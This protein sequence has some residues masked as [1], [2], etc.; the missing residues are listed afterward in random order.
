MSNKV[1]TK[2]QLITVEEAENMLDVC[3]TLLRQ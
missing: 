2:D 1:I 3:S